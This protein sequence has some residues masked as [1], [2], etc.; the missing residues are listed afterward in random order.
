MRFDIWY[1]ALALLMLLVGEGFGQ[2]MAGNDHSLAL[3]HAHLL[4]IAWVSF[5][6]FGLIHRAYP[7]L[8][9]SPL[10]LIQFLMMVFSTAF[11]IVGLWV[12]MIAGD[13]L[14]AAVG[15][16]ALIASCALFVVMFFT[17]VVFA[18]SAS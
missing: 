11:F 6:L 8:A 10:A 4:V 3:V 13:P 7:V 17:K 14:G 18:A 15:S 12:V 1:I 2:W 16:Y 9:T 5:A